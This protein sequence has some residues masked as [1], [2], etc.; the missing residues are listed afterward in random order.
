MSLP[1]LPSSVKKGLACD[2]PAAMA[3]TTD[4]CSD[5]LHPL[6]I[7]TP[8]SSKAILWAAVN[9]ALCMDTRNVMTAPPAVSPVDPA[10]RTRDRTRGF[11]PMLLNRNAFHAS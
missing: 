5:L 4:N 1:R 11:A 2:I 7:S 3:R 6:T 10:G 8:T 9:P